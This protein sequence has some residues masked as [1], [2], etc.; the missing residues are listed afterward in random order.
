MGFSQAYYNVYQGLPEQLVINYPELRFDHHC[1][2]RIALDNTFSTKWDEVLPRPA[3]KN[4]NNQQAKQVINLLIRYQNQKELLLEHHQNS[5]AWRK[6]AKEHGD[7][8]LN[9]EAL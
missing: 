8:L 7:G 4:L 1:Y 6:K 9:F 2:L 5:M 3:Y